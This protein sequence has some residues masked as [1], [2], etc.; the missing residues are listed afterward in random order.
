MIVK[1]TIT[2]L[3]LLFLASCASTQ[4]TK[5]YDHF[6]GETR[7]TSAQITFLGIANSQSLKLVQTSRQG[8]RGSL[9][10]NFISNSSFGSQNQSSSSRIAF[11]VNNQTRIISNCR[12]SEKSSIYNP[13]G[14]SVKISECKYPINLT[15]LKTLAF[16]KSVSLRIYKKSEKKL[17]LSL[18]ANDLKIIRDFYNEIINIEEK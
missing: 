16:A 8:K 12:D 15:N 3:I 2:L 10:A 11:L 6:L 4:L 5:E 7:I 1:K 9:Y 18:T 13:S 14:L 17:E